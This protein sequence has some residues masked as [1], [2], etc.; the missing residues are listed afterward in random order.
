MTTLAGFARAV[1]DPNRPS[2]TGLRTWNGSDPE[3]RFSIYRNNVIVSLVDALADGFPVVQELVGE[4]FFRAMAREYVR[5]Q[6]PLSPVMVEYGGHFP[7][8]IGGFAP[9][10]ALPYLAD[11]A[12]LERARVCAIHAAEAEPLDAATLA[13]CLAA[14]ES[15]LST[16][17]SLHPSLSTLCSCFAVVSL[18]AAHQEQ[19]GSPS[20]DTIAI[21]LPEQALILRQGLEVAVVPIRAADAHFI[22]ALTEGSPL[23]AAAEQTNRDHEDFDLTQALTLLLRLQAMVGL[24]VAPLS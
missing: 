2:P 15:L 9:A 16:R 22:D 6:P 10:A 1:L 20:L 13:A 23:S 11:V 24:E 12:R 8:F 14:P 18:W 5:I 21:E 3:Q 4:M 7:D 17:I 19:P